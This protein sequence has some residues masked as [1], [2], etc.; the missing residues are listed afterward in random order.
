MLLSGRER[1]RK[2]EKMNPFHPISKPAGEKQRELDKR[3]ERDKKND[4]M[5]SMMM[6]RDARAYRCQR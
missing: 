4:I 2:R 6:I 1:E 5:F 3:R